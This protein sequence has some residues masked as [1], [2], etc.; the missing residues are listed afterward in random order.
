MNSTLNYFADHVDKWSH[1]VINRYLGGDRIPPR[2]VWEHVHPDLVLSPQGHVV[3][4][5]TVVDKWYSTQSVEAVQEACGFRWK[6]EE[7]HRETKQVTGIEECQ[8]RTERI[9]RNHIGCA[10]LVWVR[11]KHLACQTGQTLYKIKHNL[12]DE[13]MVQQLKNP[14]V[15]MALA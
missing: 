14:T 6:I 5:D 7:F 2:L 13:Y 10:V 11:L 1:D 9:Q 3:F 12:L 15:Q 4:D 8:C